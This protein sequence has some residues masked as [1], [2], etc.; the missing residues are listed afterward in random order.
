[1]KGAGDETDI[2]KIRLQ[3]TKP[4]TWVPLIWGTASITSR[5]RLTRRV[6]LVTH[7]WA[8]WQP[9]SRASPP[10]RWSMQRSALFE[11]PIVMTQPHVIY[12][13]SLVVCRYYQALLV[14]VTSCAPM[15]KL[16][17]T[18]APV[19]HSSS[20]SNSPGQDSIHH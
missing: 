3:L 7:E 12:L 11:Q 1:M 5:R 20:R 15:H 18:Q 13:P 8:D 17:G 6:F 14:S 10:W 19:K 16:T 4:V 9:R 2:W